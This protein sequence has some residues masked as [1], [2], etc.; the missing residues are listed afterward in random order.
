M[1]DK[2]NNFVSLILDTV[3]FILAFLIIVPAIIVFLDTEANMMFFPIIF[4]LTS[5]ICIVQIVKIYKGIVEYKY[6]RVALYFYAFIAAFFILLAL[7]S[8]VRM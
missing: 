1:A 2:N 6:K 8:L 7:V 4:F 3:H 5:M